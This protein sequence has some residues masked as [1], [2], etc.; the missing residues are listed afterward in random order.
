MR[1]WENCNFC[2][3]HQY[4][5]KFKV[6]KLFIDKENFKST[7]LFKTLDDFLKILSVDPFFVFNNYRNQVVIKLDNPE[8]SLDL[9]VV[10]GA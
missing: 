9:P 7:F 3:K 5:P 2:F 4:K 6:C 8:H 1:S 10:V